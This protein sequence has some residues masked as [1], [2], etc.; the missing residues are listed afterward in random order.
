MSTRCTAWRLFTDG[1]FVD[2]HIVCLNSYIQTS[3][4]G[5][6]ISPHCH[7][8]PV[9]SQTNKYILIIPSVSHPEPSLCILFCQ[10]SLLCIESW[11]LKYSCR[12]TVSYHC[13]CCCFNTTWVWFLV[14]VAIESA[15]IILA[16]L[17]K[18]AGSHFYLSSKRAFKYV[19]KIYITIDST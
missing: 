10:S 6:V 14:A 17:L 16:V 11:L 4:C 8:S 13:T 1:D 2:S 15:M 12:Q 9:P 18:K 19:L 3:G 7:Q 5:F